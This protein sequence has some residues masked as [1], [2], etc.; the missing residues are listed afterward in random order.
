MS[1]NPQQYG[2][3]Q[4]YGQ[5]QQG[6]PQQGQGQPGYGQQGYPQQQ[7]GQQQPQGYGQQGYG[8]QPQGY[9]QQYGQQQYGQQGF[10]GGYGSGGHGGGPQLA[11][12]GARLGARILDG[13]IVGIPAMILLSVLLLPVLTSEATFEVDENGRLTSEAGTGFLVTTLI[14]TVVLL[15][16]LAAY[17]ILMLTK[18]NGQTL[19]K[20]IVNI[21]VIKEN[22]G[23]L[24]TADAGKRWAVLSLP[25]LIP[26]IGWLISLLV[27]LSPLFDGQR[28]QGWHD[29][30]A[31]TLV[32]N[33]R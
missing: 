22:G 33:A 30:A 29:K 28:K 8:Q 5:P 10:G 31:G 2:Q 16:A 32:V 18:R 21:R 25:G 15:G 4:P 3:Q 1:E 6:Y 9:Q 17:E 26:Y 27:A 20:Q 24:D 12:L 19:G 7:Y 11:G 14:T 23:P 13:L